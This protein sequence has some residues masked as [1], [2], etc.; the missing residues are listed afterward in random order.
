MSEEV[1]LNDGK[2]LYDNVGLIQTLIIDCNDLPGLLFS[3]RYVAFCKKIVEMVQKLSAVKT[4]IEE[5]AKIRDKEIADLKQFCENL[6][7]EK[8]GGD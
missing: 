7:N 2:G 1:K 5:E 3:N 8:D 4:G 6:L